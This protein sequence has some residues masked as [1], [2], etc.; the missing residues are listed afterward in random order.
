MRSLHLQYQPGLASSDL[1]LEPA[2]VVSPRGQASAAAPLAQG[3]EACATLERGV[4]A[5]C[6]RR[7]R[8]RGA[9][10]RLRRQCRARRRWRMSWDWMAESGARGRAT[11]VREIRC[12]QCGGFAVEIQTKDRS[13]DYQSG[14]FLARDMASHR[15]RARIKPSPSPS[16]P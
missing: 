1:G 4:S 2:L 12:L 8:R 6:V 5:C 3:D 13:V 16:P 10:R 15:T 9:R 11:D 7:E 14:N